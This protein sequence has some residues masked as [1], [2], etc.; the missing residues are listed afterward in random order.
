[1]FTGY[2]GAEFAQILVNMLDLAINPSRLNNVF[3]IGNT[4]NST[5]IERNKE[6]AVKLIYDSA[7]GLEELF[8]EGYCPRYSLEELS[9]IPANTLGYTY[10][11]HMNRNNLQTLNY[12]VKECDRYQF[13]F[14][15]LRETHDILHAITGFQTDNL[16]EIGLEGFYIAQAMLPNVYYLMMARMSHI[17][18]DEKI[19]DGQLY[20][21]TVTK[22]FQMGK[23]A[24][25]VLGL[26]WEDMFWE[27]I[28]ILRN[29]LRI[30][31]SEEGLEQKLAEQDKTV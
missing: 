4:V 7:P 28:K 22:G 23:K 24:K 11:T 9:T 17:L 13:F 19:F 10:A 26:R 16:G 21:E 6:K 30:V 1:M 2:S 25:K 8:Q 12:Q 3:E 5:L 15:R 14:R 20:L 27:D 31:V 18:L 29:K